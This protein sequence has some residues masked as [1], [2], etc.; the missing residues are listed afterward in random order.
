M[1]DQHRFHHSRFDRFLMHTLWFS[2]ALDIVWPKSEALRERISV[3]TVLLRN[4]QTVV[5]Y[6]EK[7][8][9]F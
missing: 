1:R 9:A 2:I 5:S 7:F 8:D 3:I 6:Q 4:T